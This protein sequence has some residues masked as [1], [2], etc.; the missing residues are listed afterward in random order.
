MDIPFDAALALVCAGLLGPVGDR[1]AELAIVG[2]LA[3]ARRE[4]QILVKLVDAARSH[5]G[6]A[7]MLAS[8]F[9]GEKPEV[10]IILLRLEYMNKYE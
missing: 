10:L 7:L 6:P 5:A 9:E 3:A 2:R 8:L 4:G 1:T